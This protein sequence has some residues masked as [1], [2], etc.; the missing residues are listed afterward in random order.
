MQKISEGIVIIKSEAKKKKSFRHGVKEAKKK[1]E[2][3]LCIPVPVEHH[4][5]LHLIA[6]VNLALLN[7]QGSKISLR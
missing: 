7:P 5:P 4:H 2:K 6:A 3:N 1:K